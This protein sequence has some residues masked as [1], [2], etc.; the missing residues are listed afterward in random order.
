MLGVIFILNMISNL[1]L[2]SFGSIDGVNA[3]NKQNT[4][5][6]LGSD[7]KCSRFPAL[8]FAVSIVAKVWEILWLCLLFFSGQCCFQCCWCMC[9]WLWLCTS[10]L[11]SCDFLTSRQNM[12]FCQL[13]V[14]QVLWYLS[15]SGKMRGNMSFKFCVAF[16]NFSK[17]IDK[18]HFAQIGHICSHFYE[19]CTIS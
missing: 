14:C 4:C 9:L 15:R 6:N 8:P 11:L 13:S 19:H 17:F 5:L 12:S 10:V 7:P 2:F 1:I 18:T 3:T 16:N